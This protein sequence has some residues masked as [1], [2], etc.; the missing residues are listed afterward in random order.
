MSTRSHFDT[1]TLSF[2]ATPLDEARLLLRNV[3]PSGHLGPEL[4]FLP[5]TLAQLVGQ[6][7]GITV[8][9]LRAFLTANN[10]PQQNLGGSLTQPVSRSGNNSATGTLAKYFV[11][12]DTSSPTFSGDFP[13][14]INS[15]DWSG[16][17]LN[18]HLGSNAAAHLF[19]N[20]VGDSATGHDYSQPWRATKIENNDEGFGTLTKGL[21][22]HH[23]LLQPRRLDS[24]G[25]DS[26][27]PEPGFTAGQYERLAL[28]FVAASVRRGTWMIPAFHA[29]LDDFSDDAHD[30]PQ[31]FS[32]TQWDAAV[33]RLLDALGHVV[34]PVVANA[35]AVVAAVPQGVSSLFNDL[36]HLYAGMDIEF[37]QLKAVTI[38]QWMLESGRGSSDLA[39]QHLNFGGLKYRNEMSGW[40]TSVFYEAHDGG[41]PYCKFDSLRNFIRGYWHFMDR[42]PYDGWRNH[43][44]TGADYIRFI[45]PIYDTAAYPNKVLALLNEAQLLLDAAAPTPGGVHALAVA[46]FMAAPGPVPAAAGG[47][48]VIDPGHGGTQKVGGSSPNNATARPSGTLEKTMTLDMA[49]RV[50]TA[51]NNLAPNVNVL[52]TRDDDFNVGI[53][54]R[55][56]VA[57]AN[58]ANLFLSIHFN[59]S[60]SHAPRGVETWVRAVA[61]GNINFAADEAFAR[62]IQAAAF[63]A[64]S[65]ID[66]QTKDRKVKRDDE[67]HMSLG[68]LNDNSLGTPTNG[69]RACLIELEFIDVPAV[70]R[71]FNTA[72]NAN[73]NKDAIAAA[74]AQALVNSLPAGGPPPPGGQVGAAAFALVPPPPRPPRKAARKA[75]STKK[76]VGAKK[77]GE[78]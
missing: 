40:A 75:A 42:D 62:N 69:C 39:T 43:I 76:S 13:A 58:N 64:L 65:A 71:L 55:A 26:I 1:H 3:L 32:L 35:A 11:I 34:F 41:E 19:I 70:D 21:F 66:P 45:G 52:L 20:R 67:L 78:T 51:V 36:V 59:D 47:I 73:A 6:T 8:Q 7:C 60:E 17:N 2:A 48:I 57:A 29:V 31:K 33:G 16:N 4:A 38:A 44:A 50:R 74:L 14:N 23:E 12:H 37:P 10:I 27:S 61:N 25:H 77:H 63:A 30:D 54:A 18:S 9:R 68:V 56:S 15:A 24:H 5:T 28:L 53:S 46:N 49:L 72:A 22:L